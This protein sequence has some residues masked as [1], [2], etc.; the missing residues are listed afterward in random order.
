MAKSYYRR[1][2]KSYVPRR[3]KRTLRYK[4]T[5]VRRPHYDGVASRKI[6]QQIDLTADG[7]GNF[8]CRVFWGTGVTNVAT[9]A[10]NFGL[11]NI[12]EHVDFLSIYNRYRIR[13]LK[14]QIRFPQP[15]G[16][17][18][19]VIYSITSASDTRFPSSLSNFPSLEQLQ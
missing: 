9:T 4:R 1:R 19:Y 7:G 13:G 15:N 5:Q 2:R 12:K 18:S 14:L 16:N 17:D 10:N 6:Y 11:A 8:D 3:R